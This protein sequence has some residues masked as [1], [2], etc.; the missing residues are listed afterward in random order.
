MELV[1][2]ATFNGVTVEHRAPKFEREVRLNY[3]LAD[4]S[5][6]KLPP[7]PKHAS[8]TV[9]TIIKHAPATIRLCAVDEP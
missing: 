3:R 4:G 8:K 5:T 6:I 1:T 7:E 2:T 9:D